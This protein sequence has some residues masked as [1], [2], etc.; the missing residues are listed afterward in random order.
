M[1][2]K[3]EIPEHGIIM[4]MRPTDRCFGFFKQFLETVSRY[5]IKYNVVFKNPRQW[6]MPVI[7]AMFVAARCRQEHADVTQVP[8]SHGHSA[9]LQVWTQGLY[10]V[11]V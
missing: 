2:V 8:L 10:H 9:V 1:V 3:T 5:H 6:A 7:A 4:D 11:F